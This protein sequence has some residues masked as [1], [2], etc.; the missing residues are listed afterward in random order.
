MQKL[1]QGS[2]VDYAQ[3]AGHKQVKSQYCKRCLYSSASATPMQFDSSGICMG[4]K[5]YE[6]KQKITIKRYSEL[7]NYLLKIVKTTLNKGKEKRKYDCIVSVSGGKD[8]YY[9]VHYVKE[10]LGLNP[11]L[12]TYNGNNYTEIGW[13]NLWNMRE[14]FDCDHIVISPSVKTIKKLNRLAFAVMGDMNWHAH[15]GIFTTAPK[16]AIDQ[17][18]PLIFWGE[19]GYADLC[20][21]F[22]MSDFPEMN[23]RERTEHAGRG[24]DWPFFVGLDGLTEQDMEPWKY[25]SDQEIMSCGLRQIYLGHYIPWESNQHLELVRKRYG[26]KVSDEPFERTYR[27]VVTTG[28]TTGLQ[29]LLACKP[30][31]ELDLGKSKAYSSNI[32]PICTSES[33]L[34]FPSISDLSS[35][36][37]SARKTLQTRWRHVGSSTL[38]IS[39]LIMDSL[40]NLAFQS[41]FDWLSSVCSLS[42]KPPKWRGLTYQSTVQKCN[43][44]QNTLSLKSSVKCNKVSNSLFAIFKA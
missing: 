10:E 31:F 29:A 43:R 11:L 17:N 18:I 33:D 32:L 7:R 21:Q 36:F 44:I 22:S 28:C 8:S 6:E 30:S 37:A 12:V 19:H 20:G 9:Q 2:Y 25:P 40:P 38:E 14:A 26:F 4:C 42:P 41:S 15:V 13:S 35:T 16:V 23:Y 3:Y 39:D 1:I 34:T 27:A 24:F 5:V